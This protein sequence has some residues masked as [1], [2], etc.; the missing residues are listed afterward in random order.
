MCGLLQDILNYD[1][2]FKECRDASITRGIR[3]VHSMT[4]AMRHPSWWNVKHPD[5]PVQDTTFHFHYKLS[6]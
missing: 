1:D 5:N 3:A 4:F 6:M 2:W